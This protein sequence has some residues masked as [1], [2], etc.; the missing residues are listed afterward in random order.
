MCG[1]CSPLD[2]LTGCGQRRCF[3]DCDS[4]GGTSLS[5]FADNEKTL[6]RQSQGWGTDVSQLL[7]SRR[8][9][10]PR[11]GS[12]P[13]PSLMENSQALA[14][15]GSLSSWSALTEASRPGRRPLSA[16][17]SARA[18]RLSGARPPHS[19]AE[20]LLHAGHHALDSRQPWLPPQPCCAGCCTGKLYFLELQR[21]NILT[22]SST[23]TKSKV[24]FLF[25]NPEKQKQN[26]GNPQTGK[27][28]KI[29]QTTY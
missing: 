10:W 23:N 9:W 25:L 4:P 28:N 24:F 18:V 13:L 8:A 20:P 15:R 26:K 11:A 3:A 16:E 27:T 6:G 17:L 7:C 14:G 19:P 21:F 22:S 2:H 5:G 1:H 29:P 12:P